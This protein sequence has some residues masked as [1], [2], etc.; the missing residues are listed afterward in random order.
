MYKNY[1]NI[2]DLNLSDI[3]KRYIFEKKYYAIELKYDT[4]VRH[5]VMSYGTQGGKYVINFDTLRYLAL[6]P[7]KN[8]VERI[9]KNKKNDT[10]EKVIAPLCFVEYKTKYYKMVFDF[11]F[12]YEKYPEIYNDFMGQNDEI[13]FYINDKI[14]ETLKETLNKPDIS[15]IT[16][17]KKKSVGYHIYY[18]NIIVNKTLHK[19]IYDTTL[20]KIN[21]DKKYPEILIRQIFDD[22]IDAN[23]VR[24]WYYKNNDDYYYPNQ[25][26]STYKFQEEPYKHFHLCILN[27]DYINY[28][29]NLLINEDVI[30]NNSIIVDTKQKEKDI[31]KG[32]I[33]SDIEY[34]SDFKTIDLGDKKDLFIGLTKIIKEDRIKG[35]KEWIKLIFMHMN[36]G[37]E[38]EKMIELSKRSKEKFD[39]N[40]IKI[41][42]DIYDKKITPKEKP[43]LF[44]TLIHWAKEDNL[45][46]ANKLFSKY[47]LSLKLN[48]DNIDDILLSFTKIKPHFSEV[49]QHISKTAI[50][51]FK[52]QILNETNCLVMKSP[53]NTGKTTAIMILLDYY[54]NIEKN[55]TVLSIVTRRSMSACHLTAFNDEKNNSKLKFYSYL[56][57]SIESL[58]YFISS[59]E[60]L[61]RVDDKYDVIILDEINSLINYFYSSTLNNKRL[62]CIRKLLE[63]I[64]KAKIV[65]GVDANI[66]D[67]VF[68]FLNQLGKNIYFY[69][70]KYQNKKDIPLNLYYSKK[71]VMELNVLAFCEKFIINKYIKQN[72]SILILS[73][74]REITDLL[75]KIF[76][77]HNSN[78]DY[79]RIF[80]KD[81]GTLQD[82]IDINKIGDN[83]C[84]IASPKWCYGLDL[85]INYLE[86]FVIYNY[87]SG[88]QSMGALEMIQQISRARN[89]KSI[90]L[91]CLDPNA[92]YA[93]NQYISYEDNKKIQESYINGYAKFHNDLCK[94]YSSINEMGCT[95]I[96]IDGKIKFN[97]NSFMTQIHYLKTWYD[98]LFHRNKVDIIKLI[99]K[100]Y[101]YKITNYEWDPDFQFVRS[102]KN[103]M[104]FKKEELVEITRKIYLGDELDNK[105]KYCIDNLK[106]QIKMREKYLK[107][108]T[109]DEILC[110]LVCD[111]T[112]FLNYINRK[113]FDL[114]KSDFEKKAIT[115][116]NNDILHMIKDNDVINKI[117]V[118]FWFEELL[119]IKR[120][121]IENINIADLANMKK[122][123]NENTEKFYYIYKNNE[124]K[125]KTIKSIKYKIES[126]INVNYLQ[127]FIAECYNNIIE[128][129]I[130]ITKKRNRIDSKT[131]FMIYSFKNNKNI[132]TG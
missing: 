33:K 3:K 42:N 110:D 95:M 86:I 49:S 63:L 14:I 73:D 89:T 67:M 22:C 1:F 57:E 71:S 105:Y 120:L 52:T 31:K 75:K 108:I 111:H 78:E 7:D 96:D 77:K 91:L 61:I 6:N 92:S 27:T 82:M 79:Y 101:G 13:T 4:T 94:K 132:T 126:I 127:K 47:Y 21:L 128:G 28:N 80:N 115:I 124:C 125:N 37:I 76:I 122:I 60:N 11:D 32:I 5:D 26:K 123:F 74:S 36:Y 104:K 54:M 48:V 16:S 131:E 65:I 62:L 64:S 24:L 129:V 46:E 114:S 109:D 30:Y 81:E 35:R 2:D 117:N 113:Y 41:I 10:Y 72:K 25:E 29:F 20:K 88:L 118:C 23:G 51:Q 66:T 17:I 70:N 103:N 107:N 56:D 38:R 87:T 112:K 84:L 102:L 68:V 98:Q 44:G 93:F 83:R 19:Y 50:E 18:P 45:I 90:N 85:L 59:L 15:Y 99:A 69:E 121:E 116:N 12:K 39:D 119:N 55:T 100:D 43:I 34:I 9:V 130:E 97:N 53:T 8:I 106:E 40:S 58:D